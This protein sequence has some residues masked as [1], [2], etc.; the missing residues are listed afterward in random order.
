MDHRCDEGLR[1]KLDAD[2]EADLKEEAGVDEDA[3]LEARSDGEAGL[4]LWA[5]SCR[6]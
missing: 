3:V 6:P 4:E 2:N 5:E 1:R